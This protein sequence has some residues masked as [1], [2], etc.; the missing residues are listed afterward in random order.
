MFR[1]SKSIGNKFVCLRGYSLSILSVFHRSNLMSWAKI[2]TGIMIVLI[3]LISEGVRL[4]TGLPITIIDIGIIPVTCLLIY[5]I[6][7]YTFPFSK[8]YTDKN[9][10]QPLNALQ[11]CGFL[12]FTVMLAIFGGWIASLG[13]QEPL[14]YFSSV[15]GGAHGYTLI[16]LGAITTIYSAGIGIIFLYR[17]V[18]LHYKSA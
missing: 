10:Q 15:K 18:Q 8:K 2:Q 11:L 5:Y 17:L 6:R 12:T 13:I 16:Q 7:F 4:Y 1:L 9:T 14:H 3:I